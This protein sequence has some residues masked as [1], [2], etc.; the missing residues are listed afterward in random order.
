M[1]NESI[2]ARHY[3]SPGLLARI[4]AGLASL[5]KGRESVSIDD[6]APVDEFHVRG[7][8]ATAELVHLLQPAPDMHV[9]DAG[10]GL[11]GSARRL[12]QTVGCRVTGVD[13]SED[14]CSVGGA[15]NQWTGLDGKVEIEAGDATELGRFPNE[16]FDA[17]WTVHAA[18]NIADK[19]KL[20]R[21]I[22]RVLKSGARVVTYDIV[23]TRSG[24]LDFPLP[25]AMDPSASFLATADELRTALDEARLQHVELIDRTGECRDFLAQGAKQLAEKGPPPLGLHLLFGPMFRDMVGNLARNFADGRLAAAVVTCRKAG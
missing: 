1:C 16:S 3:R 20:Y 8:Q 14:Y 15:L 10:C 5:G 21:E 6:L 17:A 13:L 11:G 22:A 25:W 23:T 4:E 24:D 2:A 12:A 9:L 19:S 7:A 18:M